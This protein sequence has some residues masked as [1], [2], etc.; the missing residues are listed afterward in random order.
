MTLYAWYSKMQEHKL[1]HCMHY[2]T[3]YDLIV[4]VTFISTIPS[5][6]SPYDDAE[7]IG[8]VS[9]YVS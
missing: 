2:K 6:I 7:Y 9:D 8:P 5:Y 1:H 3:S 4:P